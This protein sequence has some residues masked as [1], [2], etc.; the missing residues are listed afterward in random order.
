MDILGSS[1]YGRATHS[2]RL[3]RYLG[4]ERVRQVSYCMRDWYGPPIALQGVP[5]A[6]YANRGGDFVGRIEAGQ[7][8][9]AVDRLEAALLRIDRSRMARRFHRQMGAFA[10]WSALINAATSGKRIDMWFSKVGTA[11]TAA[12]GC[13]D[14]WGVGN[15]PAAGAQGA[16]AG[17]GT[18]WTNS[19]TGC[20]P[21][22]NA[23]ANANTSH[24]MTAWA[25][26]NFQ[27][28]LLLA[29]RLFSVAKTASSL[30]AEAVTGTFSRYQNQTATAQDYIG[31]N[32]MYPHVSSAGALGA[33][34]HNWTVM[35]YTDQSGS[36][37]ISAPSFAGITS[38][39][40]NQVD[41]ALGN[42]FMPLASGDTGVKALTQ[43]QNSA[44]V[45]GACD[46]VISHPIAFLPCPLATVTSIIDGV[47]SAFNL[48]FIFDNACL[49]LMEMPKPATNATTYSGQI[50]SVSE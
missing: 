40:A 12:Q 8:C 46:W 44:S 16:A 48:Q 13:I 6:V 23:V 11:P 9:S 36:T 3:E 33:T 1:R 43:M 20:L 2:D 34:G 7:E 22:K 5:G 42:W 17:A 41:L 10:T 15:Q 35:Q 21:F 50:S 30:T 27:N 38:C 26:A 4:A 49:Y 31:G 39:A 32:F 45:T 28:T 29:D 14:L 19:S 18:A 24:F 37:A 25:Q 47:G